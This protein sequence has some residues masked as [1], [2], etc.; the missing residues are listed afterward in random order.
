MRIKYIHLS[1][2]EGP[3]EDLHTQTDAVRD[4]LWLTKGL[5]IPLITVAI[6]HVPCKRV[7]AKGDMWYVVPTYDTSVPSSESS[8]PSSDSS[9]RN[10]IVY[11]IFVEIQHVNM[12]SRSREDKKSTVLERMMISWADTSFWISD[13]L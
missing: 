7:A 10:P 3:H 11:L 5:Q 1:D 4:F 12:V 2:S 13:G 6:I 8:V 9:D